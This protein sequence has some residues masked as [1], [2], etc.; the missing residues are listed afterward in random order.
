MTR[1]VMVERCTRWRRSWRRGLRRGRQSTWSS[2]RVSGSTV[3]INQTIFCYLRL[4]WWSREHLGT[5][6]QP[7]L[8]RQD[9]RFWE[10]TQGK[11]FS[12]F[13]AAT[14]AL[15]VQMLVCVS[16]RHTCYNCTK[17]LNFKVFRLKDF[18]RTSKGLLKDFWRTSEGL[19][20]NFWRTSEGLLDFRL[21]NLLSRSPQVF[22]TC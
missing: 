6:W 14:A 18:Y 9:P 16:V 7:R 20:E 13:L 5:C 19:L 10:E 3:D 12:W 1:E 15:E 4:W 11:I 8:W 17:A 2:G 22:E 21:Q